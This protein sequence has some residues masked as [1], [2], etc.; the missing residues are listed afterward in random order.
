M[1]VVVGLVLVSFVGMVVRAVL[2]GMLVVVDACRR[3]MV[4]GML[5]VVAVLV[6]MDMHMLVAVPAGAR[7]FVLVLVFVGV[8]VGMLVV[9][10]VVALHTAHLLFLSYASSRRPCTD[11][12]IFFAI[13]QDA[14]NEPSCSFPRI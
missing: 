7:M 3:A 13:A 10:F 8:L 14:R 11:G 4:V 2:A 12:M 9:M 1:F 5:V 6:G